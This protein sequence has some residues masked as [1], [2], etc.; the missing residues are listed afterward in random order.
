MKYLL[1][2]VYE[3]QS[4]TVV[5]YREQ[6]SI[7]SVYA[8]G[9]I[10]LV[11]LLNISLSPILYTSSDSTFD[12]STC[13]EIFLPRFSRGICALSLRMGRERLIEALLTRRQYTATEALQARI[14]EGILS[15]EEFTEQM[16]KASSLSVSATRLANELAIRSRR[17]STEQ[18]ETVERYAF[19]LRF[20]SADQKEGMNAF[21]EKRQPKFTAD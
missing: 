9:R 19:A 12:L 3:Q 20:T 1:A 2:A 10:D 21:L 6:N 5:P 7:L 17:L 16:E 14:V 15:L 4:L 11:T 13:Q 18:A 8:S